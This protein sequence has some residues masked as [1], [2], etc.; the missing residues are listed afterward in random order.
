MRSS[1]RCLVFPEPMFCC[2]AILGAPSL[3]ATVK[4]SSRTFGLGSVMVSFLSREYLSAILS[5]GLGC[6]LPPKQANMPPEGF[7]ATHRWP[8][9]GS[10]QHCP[11]LDLCTSPETLLSLC[12][13]CITNTE[14]LNMR[15]EHVTELHCSFHYVHAG[16]GSFLRLCTHQCIC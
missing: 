3:S 16:L 7:I 4:L 10:K 14:K 15:S 1:L 13:I 11:E 6:L 8:L 9:C 2:S 5:L 12:T